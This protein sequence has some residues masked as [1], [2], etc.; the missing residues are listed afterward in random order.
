MKN[1]FVEYN[2]EANHRVDLSSFLLIRVPEEFSNIIT[3]RIADQDWKWMNDTTQNK[4][5]QRV[6]HIHEHANC[7]IL[8]KQN[9]KMN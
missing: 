2:I 7:I 5:G 1:W 8:T 3:C 9:K 4:S 6:K